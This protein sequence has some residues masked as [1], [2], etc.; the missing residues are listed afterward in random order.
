MSFRL[1]WTPEATQTVNELQRA[2]ERS[3]TAKRKSSK[4][5]GVFKQV[6]KSIRQLANDP[7]HPSLSTQEYDSLD[8]PFEA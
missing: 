6:A 2:A 4:Q 1:R 8:H 3:V 5:A 7:R